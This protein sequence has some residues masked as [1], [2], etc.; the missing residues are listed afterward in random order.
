MMLASMPP[1]VSSML[2]CITLPPAALTSR[3][4]RLQSKLPNRSSTLPRAFGDM[5]MFVPFLS[6]SRIETF[7]LYVISMKSDIEAPPSSI[8]TTRSETARISFVLI[9][10]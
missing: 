8:A 9:A 6:D 5:E 3:N 7:E 2:S 10:L 1:G 4:S